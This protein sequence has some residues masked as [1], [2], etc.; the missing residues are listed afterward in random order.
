MER[1]FEVR[2]QEM[3]AAAEIGPEVLDELLPQLEAFLQPYLAG[4][5]RSSQQG[6]VRDYVRGLV[7]DLESKTVEG[8]AYLHDHERQGLQK[9]IGQ[10]TWDARPLTA[11]LAREVAADLGEPDGVLV[12]DPAGFAK[13][14]RASVGVARQWC[15]RLGKVENCQVGVYLGY[16]SRREQALVDERL[17]LPR[18]W[19][20]DRERRRA[21]GVPR[22][23]PFATR[24]A[25]AL[26]MLRDHGGTLPHGW[27]AGD[28]EMGRSTEFRSD[29][30][31]L[32]ERYLLAVPANTLVRDL[33]A[34][35]PPYGGHG[36]QPKVAMQPA[37]RWVA[38][39]PAAAWQRVEVRAGAKG[40][41]AVEGV[42]VRVQTMCRRSRLG[43]DELLVVFRERQADGSWKHDYLL[44]NA[45]PQTPLAELARVF[46]AEHR[47]EQCLQR[48]KGEAGL[49]D[50]E[51]R[52]WQGW[53]HHQALALIAT[54][55]LTRQTRREKKSD[56]A[57]DGPATAD[58]DR[59]GPARG[60]RGRHPGP[61]PPHDEPLGPPHRRGRTLPLA[62]AQPL[63]AESIAITV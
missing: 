46:N 56:A 43:P 58:A 3:I 4:F 31:A 42:T 2:L 19:A 15:G 39:L 62:T 5:P 55:F 24:H 11:Q 37:R 26:E 14:G 63:A 50:S 8:I 18:E 29:L 41:L 7:S 33:T 52:T 10:G 47:I 6:H 44:S 13:K 36:S 20:G 21:A 51:V 30:R 54:W 53:H 49:A 28:D 34:P 45:S 60:P 48:A 61:L 32:G 59:P 27:V 57:G 16:V 9:F 23:T 12:F 25:L 17:Y 38:G 22:G 1:R 35:P 40:P